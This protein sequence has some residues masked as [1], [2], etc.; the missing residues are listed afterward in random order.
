MYVSKKH[1]TLENTRSMQVASWNNGATTQMVATVRL[2]SQNALN[3]ISV[4]Y[5]A[6][7]QFMAART[8]LKNN[9]TV[10]SNG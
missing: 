8:L 4:K 3:K 7:T 5:I 10:L 1:S 2:K 9:V 6:Y